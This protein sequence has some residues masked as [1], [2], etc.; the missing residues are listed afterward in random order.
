[1][2]LGYQRIRGLALLILDTTY[3]HPQYAFPAQSEA[4]R[5]VLE[6]I[7]AETFNPATL[8]LVG[9]YTIGRFDTL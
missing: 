8:F 5:F 3:C 6:A 9:T 7:K 1:M 2:I 4:I